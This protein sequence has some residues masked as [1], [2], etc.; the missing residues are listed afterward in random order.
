MLRCALSCEIEHRI[1]FLLTWPHYDLATLDAGG[2]CTCMLSHRRVRWFFNV[3][4][5]SPAKKA[6]R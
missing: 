2:I 6:I 4:P 1:V 5:I 3:K